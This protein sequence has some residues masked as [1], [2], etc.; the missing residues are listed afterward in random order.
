MRRWNRR[1]F[2]LR[3]G[4]LKYFKDAND[5]ENGKVSLKKVIIVYSDNFVIIHQVCK[6]SISLGEGTLL[7]EGIADSGSRDHI[8]KVDFEAQSD[9]LCHPH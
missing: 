5:F 1:Y 9:E 8:L 4:I 6:G 3:R 7:E 2:V